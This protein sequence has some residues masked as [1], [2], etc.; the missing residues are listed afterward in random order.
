MHLD[1]LLNN[2]RVTLADVVEGWLTPK[3]VYTI[4]EFRQTAEFVTATLRALLR[5]HFVTRGLDES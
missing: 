2:L 3:L 1:I 5:A 4:L